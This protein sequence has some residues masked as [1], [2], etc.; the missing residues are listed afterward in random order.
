MSLLVMSGIEKRF[1]GVLALDGASL[2]A[3]RGEIH[4]LCGENGAGKS[5]LLKI[6]SGVHPFGSYRGEI[7]VDG[8]EARLRSTAGARARGIAIVHQELMLVPEMTVA[9]NLFLGREP[10]GLFVDGLA[11]EA[12]SRA[13]LERFGVGEIDAAAQLG[14]LGI[15]LQQMVEI[16]RALAEDARILILDEPT[17]ALTSDECARLHEW[18]LGLKKRGTTCLYV[19]HRM[20]EIFALTDRVTVLR[21]GRTAGTLET[22]QATPQKVVS[23]MVGRDLPARHA[24]PTPS[25]APALLE[26]EALSMGPLRELAFTVGAGEIV[27]IAGAMGSGRTALLSTLFGCAELPVRGRVRLDG[28]ALVLDGPRAAID[29]GLAYVPEDR[30]GRGLVLG[31]TVAENLALPSLA[32][33]ALYGWVDDLDEEAGAAEQIRA[34]GVRGELESEAATLSGGN[35][36]KVVLGKWLASPPRLLLLDEPTRGVDVGA[37]EEIYG[38]LGELSRR[39]VAILFASSDLVEL[40]RLAQRILVLR[41]GRLI[42]ELPAGS[43]QDEI[44]ELSTGAKRLLEESCA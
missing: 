43:A 20:E 13:L 2:E 29:A 15:G 9:E 11:L 31:I 3:E 36:Q 37:R 8:K 34:L 44:V 17:A 28:Q 41:K 5:T 25:T 12:Q 19:S 40:T 4:G 14:T 32:R 24:P 22:A 30:K 18:L 38:L 7:L 6:L 23:L 39:G 21:D 1:G 26:V 27:G 33:G 10:G 42:A 16:V 35:Q